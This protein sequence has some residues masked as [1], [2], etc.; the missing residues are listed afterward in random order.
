MNLIF[1]I[2]E[3]MLSVAIAI[4]FI[5]LVIGPT[6][7]NRVVALDLLAILVVGMM[8]SEAVQSGEHALLDVAV[9]VGITAFIGTAAFAVL[10]DRDSRAHKND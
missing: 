2:V 5:R 8:A 4:T 1:I 10:I 9:V 7:V 6:M 3:I